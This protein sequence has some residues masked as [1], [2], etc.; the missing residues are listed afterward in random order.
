MIKTI[1]RK[2]WM[3]DEMLEKVCV[4]GFG[5]AVL[6][7]CWVACKLL[8]GLLWLGYYLGLPM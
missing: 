7:G 4:A 3:S 6:A 8:M 5:V 2:G 1:T